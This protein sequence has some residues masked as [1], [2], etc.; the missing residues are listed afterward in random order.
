MKHCVGAFNLSSIKHA[1][2]T[3]VENTFQNFEENFPQ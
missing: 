3:S 2:A 1:L